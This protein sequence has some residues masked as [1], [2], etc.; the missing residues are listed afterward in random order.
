MAKAIMEW[1]HSTVY[2][3]RWRKVFHILQLVKNFRKFAL[4]FLGVNRKS[5]SSGCRQILDPICHSSIALPLDS[6]GHSCLR[7]RASPTKEEFDF[8]SL[9]ESF[10][11]E[12]RKTVCLSI[13]IPVLFNFE[14]MLECLFNEPLLWDSL[15]RSHGIP[16]PPSPLPPPPPGVERNDTRQIFNSE[17][18][19]LP[20]RRQSD[21]GE[22]KI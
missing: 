13:K 22:L 12:E 18:L 10:E 2:W 3:R 16:I 14:S 21:S 9:C 19:L 1:E 17:K 11:L 8:N 7:A 20:E 6:F 5:S 15:L 4:A